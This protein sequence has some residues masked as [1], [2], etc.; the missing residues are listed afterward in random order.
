MPLSEKFG[1]HYQENIIDIPVSVC[2]EASAGSIVDFPLICCSALIIALSFSESHVAP[3]FSIY[4]K[5]CCYNSKILSL[6]INCHAWR[7]IF[8]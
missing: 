1:L 4:K 7:E 2:M 5:S 6:K 8:F 3:I